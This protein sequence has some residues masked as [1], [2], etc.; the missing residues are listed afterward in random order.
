MEKGKIIRSL[1]YKFTERFAVKGIGLVISIVLGRLLAPD[2]FGQIALVTVFTDISLTLIDGGLNTALV[3]SR[4][5][6][7]RD[8][9]TVFYITC[10]LSLVMIA[11]LQALSPVIAAYY[12]APELIGPLRV[13]SFS[14][15][16]SSFNSIQVARLQRE[17]RFREMMFCNLAATLV[18]GA[19]GVFLALRG[20]GIWALLCY[21]FAQ[22]LTSSL[23][24]LLVLR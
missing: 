16:F 10:A 6:D 8:Y 18:S 17:M 3:Q 13:Y 23:A 22:I 1:A 15:L 19:L 12:R 4:G 21:F 20:A 2:L 5:A 7:D 14:L 11:L 9:S 24:M